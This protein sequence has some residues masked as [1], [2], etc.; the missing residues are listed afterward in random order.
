MFWYSEAALGFLLVRE[1]VTCREGSEGASASND[2][3]ASNESKEDSGPCSQG[4]GAA[5]E[6]L[7]YSINRLHT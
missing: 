3:V 2:S 6:E 7:I 5:R 4:E 1:P